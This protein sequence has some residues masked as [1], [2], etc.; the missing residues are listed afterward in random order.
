MDEACIFIHVTFVFMR[1]IAEMHHSIQVD[2]LNAITLLL[3]IAF[4]R[5]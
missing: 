5:S 3:E 1:E 2:I 4:M